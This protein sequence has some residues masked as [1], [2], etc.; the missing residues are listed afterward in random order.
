MSSPTPDEPD[1]A[2]RRSAE[3][4]PEPATDLEPKSADPGPG[5]EPEPVVQ[6]EPIAEPEPE[7]GPAPRR[8]RPTALGITVAIIVVALVAGLATLGWTTIGTDI[9]ARR[10]VATLLD[11]TRDQ[12]RTQPP[13]AVP[14]T[15]EVVAIL[16][17]TRLGIEWPVLAGIATDQLHRGLGW[18]PQ[19]S[20]PGQLGNTAIAGLRV[21]HGSPLRH[22]VDLVPGD[23]ITLQTPTETFTYRVVAPPAQVDSGPSGAWVLDPVPGE[24]RVP[25]QALLTL[26]TAAD[27]VAT[28]RRAVVFAELVTS[29]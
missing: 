29:R 23:L 3:P 6:S 10:Q 5:A 2:P 22:L 13:D 9:V 11:Q 24:N 4:E 19:T 18:Y 16:R 27:L 12:W 7:P 15:G 20:A 14:E 8:R 28:Q 1:D 25:D 17:S 26:T 21:T